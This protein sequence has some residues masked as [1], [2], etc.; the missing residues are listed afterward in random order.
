M[1]NMEQKRLPAIA[2][3]GGGIN[4]SDGPSPPTKKP[5]TV[6]RSRK[7]CMRGKGGPE[8]SLCT[9]RGVRQRTWGKW[10]AEIREPNRGAR[11]WLGTFN[12]S[13]EAARAYDDA[14]R[15]LYGSCAKLNLPPAVTPA[16]DHGSSPSPSSSSSSSSSDGC[17]ENKNTN[18][19]N[20]N[21]NSGMWFLSGMEDDEAAIF[22][23]VNGEYSLWETP[24]PPSLLLPEEKQNLNWPEY[25]VDNGKQY[26]SNDGAAAGMITESAGDQLFNNILQAAPWTTTT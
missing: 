25:P 7:G 24:A 21:N 15:R 9:F 8:N 23:D 1:A 10:V 5:I 13:L 22:K 6:G 14:A 16:T 26:W 11:I 3:G 2:G 20:D 17:Q 4:T 18:N 19:N 12:T